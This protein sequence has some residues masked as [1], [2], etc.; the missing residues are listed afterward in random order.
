MCEKLT[1]AISRQLTEVWS[2]KLQFL[3]SGRAGTLV[4]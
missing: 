4:S 2:E 3:G 1:G